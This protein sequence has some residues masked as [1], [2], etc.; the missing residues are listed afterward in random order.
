[1]L[2]CIWHASTSDLTGL[3]EPCLPEPNWRC[4]S[5][6][7]LQQALQEAQAGHFLLF[8]SPRDGP[9]PD[10]LILSRKHISCL[11]R[12]RYQ[13]L[14]AHVLACTSAAFQLSR[15]P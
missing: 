2:Q 11:F 14:T 12:L 8:A 9:A 15:M 4:A 3:Q 1:M 5:V 6:R 10:S 7:S 13:S